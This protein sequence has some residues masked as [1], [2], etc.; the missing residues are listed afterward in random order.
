MSS[1]PLP[2]GL[3]YPDGRHWRGGLISGIFLV[4]IVSVGAMIVIPAVQRSRMAAR[5]AQF[6]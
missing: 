6:T 5:A 1:D 2:P 3:E 4:G